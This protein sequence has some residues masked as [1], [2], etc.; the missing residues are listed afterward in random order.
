M[1]ERLKPLLIG[2]GVG[3]AL[4]SLGLLLVFLF[5]IQ[6]MLPLFG[7]PFWVSTFGAMFIVYLLSAIATGF[8]A[9]RDGTLYGAMLGLIWTI[10]TAGLLGAMQYS[11]LWIFPLAMGVGALGGYLGQMLA[12][13]QALRNA[14]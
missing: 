2:L 3:A 14:S 11:Q 10:P 6:L 1:W 7:L 13:Q 4:Q 9:G 8:E 5:K 12:R